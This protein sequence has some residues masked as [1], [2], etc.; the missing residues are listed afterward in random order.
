MSDVPP[1]ITPAPLPDS[2]VIKAFQELL[3]RAPSA[4]EITEWAA[5]GDVGFM[6]GGIADS[7]EFKQISNLERVIRVRFPDQAWLLNNPEVRDILLRAV[8][9]DT[10]MDEQTFAAQIRQTGWWQQTS[11]SNRNFLAQEAVNP[12]ELNRQVAEKRFELERLANRVGAVMTPEQLQGHA[13]H[14]LYMGW[15]D[16][17]LTDSLFNFVP[18]DGSAGGSSYG[19]LAQVRQLAGDYLVSLSTNDELAWARDLARGTL[20]VETI[21]QRLAGLAKAKFGA[22]EQLVALIDSGASPATF[23]NDHRRLIAEELELDEDTVD[24][25]SGRWNQVLMTGD[26]GAVRPMTLTETRAMVRDQAEWQHTSRGRA[27]ITEMGQGIL[28]QMG[29]RA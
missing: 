11:A 8:H 21:Q 25:R 10:E 29:V 22:N 2:E 26:G 19:A 24:L 1:Q 6:R 18:G 7:P 15:S 9:P 28:Q 13:R 16:E 20:P 3:G 4:S 23:F 17:E 14:A 27:T 5:S 12:G